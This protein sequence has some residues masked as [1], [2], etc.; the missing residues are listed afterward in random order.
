[1]SKKELAK[2]SAKL[3]ISTELNTS[4]GIETIEDK[5]NR[6]IRGVKTIYNFGV[7]RGFGPPPPSPHSQ[8][9]TSQG[10]TLRRGIRR[11]AVSYFDSRIPHCER[12]PYGL[13]PSSALCFIILQQGRDDENDPEMCRVL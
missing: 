13:H 6:K 10:I 8:V 11:N 7:R 3:T 12:L 4:E 1:M 2:E 9:Y 5:L